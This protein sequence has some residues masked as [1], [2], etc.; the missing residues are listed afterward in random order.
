MKHTHV[1]FEKCLYSHAG[2]V[3]SQCE[4]KHDNEDD[5]G[6]NSRDVH[7]LKTQIT[8]KLN[9]PRMRSPLHKC[10]KV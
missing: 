2:T 5:I 9:K 7:N 4:D 8:F 6:E 3:S 1:C 10:T